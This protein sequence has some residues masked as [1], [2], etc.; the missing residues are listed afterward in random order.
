MTRRPRLAKALVVFA[1][2]LT[3]VGGI[4]LYLDR[5]VFDSGRFA[6]RATGTLQDEGVRALIGERV[7][8]EAIKARPDLVGVRPLIGAV[9]EGVVRSPPFGAL[10][11]AGVYDLHR[12]V[13][14]SDNDT[15]ALAV[16][17][18]GVLVIQAVERIQPSA[19]KRIP[20]GLEAELVRISSGSDGLLKDGLRFAED[21]RLLALICLALAALLL[22]AGVLL[23]HDRRAA[24]GWVGLAALGV[25]LATVLVFEVT[26]GLITGGAEDEQAQVAARAVWDAFL[27]DLR[28]WGLIVAAVGGVVAA[29]SA[30]LVRPVELGPALRAGWARASAMPSRPVLRVARALAFV[31]AGALVIAARDAVVRMLVLSAGIGLIYLGVAELMRLLAPSEPRVG[32]RPRI[33]LPRRLL[34]GTLVALALGGGFLVAR[35]IEP[36][37]RAVAV[38]ACNGH[39]GL[40]DRRLD[41]VTFPASHNSMS[42]AAEPGW[43]FAAH[44]KGI[45][46]QLDDGVR[47]LLIDTHYGVETDRGVVT[48][49]QSGSKSRAKIADEVGEEFVN[50]AERLRGRLGYKGGGKREVFLCH[51][52][53]EVGATRADEA[54]EAVRDFV[55]ENP[56]EVLVLS[57]EDDVTPEDTVKLFERSGLRE[58]VYDGRSGPPWPTLRELIERGQ[59]VVVFAENKTGGVPWYRQQ[60]DFV[61]ET[62]FDFKTVA[63][64]RPPES[65]RP[66]RGRPSN[67]LFL[68]NNWVDT[69]PAPRPSNA[70]KINA[71][72][73]LLGRARRC[74]RERG[75]KPNLVAVDFYATGDLF[76]TV[77]AL[78]GVP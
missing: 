20:S 58:Y 2:T 78:N 19:A 12:S 27:A 33:R 67:S 36:E 50:T 70:Q 6:D 47:S 51:A 8:D 5:T 64:L 76:A 10:F 18:V 52:Y 74:G 32:S 77:D 53:C 69:A 40:C 14:S 35:A 68:L 46:G 73:K 26:R 7:S 49:L 23:A 9:A 63:S 42:A 24:F 72:R 3:L 66:M 29:A 1:A 54:L 45:R 21:V 34:A 39:R 28:G 30:S 17:D 11:R 4:A 62:P 13:F 48:D 44:D 59:Q 61:Q 38:T 37:A 60:F 15:V 75:L 55:V 31:V 65:C 43:L 22:V 41:D 56:N 57:V 71:R 25:G 16:S